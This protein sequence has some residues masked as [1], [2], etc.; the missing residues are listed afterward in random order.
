MEEDGRGRRW[1]TADLPIPIYSTAQEE[2][3][4]GIKRGEKESERRE[5]YNRFDGRTDGGTDATRT[6]DG[7]HEHA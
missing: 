5:Y 2:K 3:K 7:V 4:G 1:R 6:D